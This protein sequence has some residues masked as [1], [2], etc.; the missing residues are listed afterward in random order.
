[1]CHP[2]EV[3]VKGMVMV[4]MMMMRRRR[5]RRRRMTMMVMMVMMTTTTMAGAMVRP[6]TETAAEDHGTDS[7]SSA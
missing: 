2:L 5:R 6:A 7:G 3:M 4:M 1:M